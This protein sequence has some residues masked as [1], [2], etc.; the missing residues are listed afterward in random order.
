MTSLAEKNA[1]LALLRSDAEFGKTGKV[2]EGQ[3]IGTDGKP[4]TGTWYVTLQGGD[5]GDEQ[6]RATGS[7]AV[8]N[9]S[10]TFQCSG[11]RPEQAMWV[12]ERL[13]GVLRPQRR[14]VRLS[15]AGSRNAPLRRDYVSGVNIDADTSPPMWFV[16]VEYSHRSQTNPADQ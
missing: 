6:D 2:F 4:I 14:G 16:T 15:V 7:Q 8:R 3:A 5:E 12:V 13:D 10:T 9:P 1:Y 11:S